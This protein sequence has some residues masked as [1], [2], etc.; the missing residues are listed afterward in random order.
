MLTALLR[1]LAIVML[2]FFVVGLPVSL[3]LRDIGALVF[4]PE[5]TK[6]LVREHLMDSELIASMARQATEQMLLGQFEGQDPQTQSSLQ[7]NVVQTV[8][9]QMSEEDWRQITELA[10]PESLVEQSVDSVVDAYT[11]WLDSE[12]EFP[13][14]VLDLQPWK[15]N[16]ATNAPQ[17]VTVVLDSLPECT[18]EMAAQMAIEGLQNLGIEGAIPACRPPEPLYGALIAN[19]PTLLAGPL[20]LAPDQFDLN[21]V[22][23]GQQA[24]DELI[25]FKAGITQVR[26]LSRWTWI[27][28]SAIGVIAVA[29][30]ARSFRQVLTW[31]GWP[32]AIAGSLVFLLALGMLFFS[33]QFL[34]DAMA[35]LF[36]GEGGTQS[37]FGAA[38][39][40][41]ALDLV[42]RPLLL[43][44][45]LIT[46]AGSAALIY[47][48]IMA[49]R[50]AS[51]GIPLN[52][53]KINL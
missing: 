32:L 18:L 8:L 19:A 34:N 36:L 9:I 31:T 44:G 46:A 13:S 16:T 25:R 30:A 12:A 5:T 49:R 42:S 4:D 50:E 48:R 1:V 45:V 10:V 37:A 17:I 11:E 47:A 14:L 6:E 24:P 26:S 53:K 23:A 51:P 28:V 7:G 39:A 21:Q 3:L 40:A 43:Q 35:N 20:A 29:M 2:V 52:Q 33:F 41:G 15:E 38:V 27:A 22:T